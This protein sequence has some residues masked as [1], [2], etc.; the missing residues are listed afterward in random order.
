MKGS[1]KKQIF[2]RGDY[3]W[4]VCGHTESGNENEYNGCILYPYTKIEK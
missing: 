3:Q 4:E 1:R 2:S